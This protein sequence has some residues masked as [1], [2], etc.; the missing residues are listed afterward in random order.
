MIGMYVG[1]I[2]FL[3]SAMVTGMFLR[4]KKDSSLVIEYSQYHS[5]LEKLA[6]LTIGSIGLVSGWNMLA[7]NIVSVLGCIM[8]ICNILSKATCHTT[9]NLARAVKVWA[10]LTGIIFGLLGVIA[11]VAALEHVTANILSVVCLS[12]SALLMVFCCSQ[13]CCLK[14]RGRLIRPGDVE[15]EE[16]EQAVEAELKVLEAF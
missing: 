14:W 12:L 16:E 5:V 10:Y 6:F 15:E 9:S 13:C 4:P 2:Y 8:L 7:V 3:S 11:D 1:G